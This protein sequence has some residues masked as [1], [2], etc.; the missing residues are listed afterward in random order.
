VAY[1]LQCKFIRRASVEFK[2]VRVMIWFILRTGGQGKGTKN[3][4]LRPVRGW[5]RPVR[6]TGSSVGNGHSQL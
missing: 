1:A 2:K 3:E 5:E 4:V 6:S